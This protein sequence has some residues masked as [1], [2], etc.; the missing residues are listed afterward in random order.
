MPIEWQV[1]C[2]IRQAMPPR[3]PHSMLP[4]RCAYAGGSSRCGRRQPQAQQITAVLARGPKLD[5]RAAR[6]QGVVMH[7]YHVAGPQT[8]MVIINAGSFFP[9]AAYGA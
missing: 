6:Q 4:Q 9:T 7:D 3:R 2:G 5:G 1:L 8:A